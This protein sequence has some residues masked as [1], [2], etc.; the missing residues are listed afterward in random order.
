M[1]FT[2]Y[3]INE[4]RA[5]SDE[6][7]LREGWDVSGA[8]YMAPTTHV[9]YVQPPPGHDYENG[10]NVVWLLLRSLPGT[11]DAGCNWSDR[12]SGFLMKTM[13]FKRNRLDAANFHLQVGRVWI[14]I[15]LHVD[16]MGVF[17]NS[18]ALLEGV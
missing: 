11:N 9:Q 7:V 18:P 16:D 15:C 8:Y 4:A 13:K 10:L 5:A 14:N 1:A 12:I 3:L 17:A 2:A 6:T